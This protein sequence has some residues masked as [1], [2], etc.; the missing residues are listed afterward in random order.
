MTVGFLHFTSDPSRPGGLGTEGNA[1]GGGSVSSGGVDDGDVYDAASD[2]AH[3]HSWWWWTATSGASERGLG[4]LQ[5]QDTP[6][7]GGGDDGTSGSMSDSSDTNLFV[8]A[9]CGC[10]GV[11]RSQIAFAMHFDT[12]SVDE[13]AW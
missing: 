4:R 8:V 5:R 2:L 1:G 6:L 3:P 9:A 7:Y 10:E 13:V 12:P 11:V